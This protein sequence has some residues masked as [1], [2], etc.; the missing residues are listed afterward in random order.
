MAPVPGQPESDARAVAAGRAWLVTG[1]STLIERPSMSR[2]DDDQKRSRQKFP[3]MLPWRD[4]APRNWARLR[5][6]WI[7][8]GLVPG[9]YPQVGWANY[10]DDSACHAPSDRGCS[11]HWNRNQI[12]YGQ[13]AG[14]MVDTESSAI[15]QRLVQHLDQSTSCS[16]PN[17]LYILVPCFLVARRSSC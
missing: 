10:R 11:V 5:Q 17:A 7:I 1:I 16:E 15:C 3:R 4:A 6:D 13:C 14:T 12:F 9:R 2:F 8:T